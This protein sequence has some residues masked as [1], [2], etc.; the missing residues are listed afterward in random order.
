[1]HIVYG[2]IIATLAIIAAEIKFDYSLGDLVKDFF[3]RIFHGAEGVAFSVEQRAKVRLAAAQ[4]KV[5][6][7]ANKIKAVV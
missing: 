1:M 2:I 3:I 5:T 4:K 7:V 6:A